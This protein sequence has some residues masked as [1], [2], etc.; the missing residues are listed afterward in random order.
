MK[1]GLFIVSVVLL[2]LAGCETVSTGASIVDGIAGRTGGA[3]GP[4]TAGDADLRSDEV[5]CAYSST[6][7]AVDNHFMAAK[8]LTPASAAT[9]NQAEVVFLDGKKTW[10]LFVVP[11]RKA[12]NAELKVGMP[13]MY[14]AHAGSDNLSADSYRQNLWYVGNVTAIDELFKGRVEVNGGK[15][16]VKYCRIPNQPLQ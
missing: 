5:L 4:V 12:T 1:R 15:Y 9:K 6:T 13:L 10:T 16:Y 2:V 8:V 3:A 11:S 14:N 7:K